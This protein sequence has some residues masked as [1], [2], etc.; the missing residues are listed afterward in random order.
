MP[1]DSSLRTVQGKINAAAI[2][3]SGAG[4][5]RMKVETSQ[6]PLDM[7]F[8]AGGQLPTNSQ[9]SGTVVGNFYI[10]KYE[11]TL[12]EWYKVRVYAL[13]N[14]YD[15]GYAGS[16]DGG[17]CPV[18]NISWH[19]AV[20]WCNAKS[21]MDGLD[22]VYLAEGGI[23]R[24]GSIVPHPNTSANGYRL[25]TE[26]EWEWAAR[27]GTASKGY[28]YSG[29]DN[30]W[31]VSWS[32]GDVWAN[33]TNPVLGH[34]LYGVRPVGTKQPNELGVHDMSGNAWEWCWDTATQ[35]TNGSRSIRGGGTDIPAGP[36]HDLGHNITLRAWEVPT[37]TD[38]DGGVITIR[39]VRRAGQ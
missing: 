7:I 35:T 37:A 30:Y 21:E 38:F 24:S 9:I 10:N 34:Q 2:P 3:L 1:L 33:S 32:L 6:T 4:F 25:P 36:P 28:T 11:V 31:E 13:S 27:G 8:V 14:G 18:G 5:Y 22:P 19:D 26:A 29:S 12:D 17:N 39:P 20:K 23:Y 15:L 16:S